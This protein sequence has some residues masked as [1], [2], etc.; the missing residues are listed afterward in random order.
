M[1]VSSVSLR[2]PRFFLFFLCILLA[3]P[4][5]VLGHA[6]FILHAVRAVLRDWHFFV[7]TW[8]EIISV[9]LSLTVERFLV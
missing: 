3:S 7:L 9:P 2:L 6:C 5:S 8:D 4:A 1:C